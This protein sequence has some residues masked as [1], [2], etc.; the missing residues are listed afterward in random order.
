M[1]DT[2]DTFEMIDD[3]INDTKAEIKQEE[4]SVVKSVASGTAI[5]SGDRK[6]V[7]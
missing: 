6:S 7:V 4:V 5:V 3:N 2:Q 1:I